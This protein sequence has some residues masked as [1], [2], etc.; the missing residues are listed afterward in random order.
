M[1]YACNP[2]PYGQLTSNPGSAT[3]PSPCFLQQSA[4]IAKV[5][6]TFW[7]LICSY[8]LHDQRVVVRGRQ[9]GRPWLGPGLVQVVCAS[10]GLFR[11]FFTIAWTREHLESYLSLSTS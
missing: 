1:L 6:E 4:T 9:L 8:P 2:L 11:Q 5:R 7:C 3:V 10:P